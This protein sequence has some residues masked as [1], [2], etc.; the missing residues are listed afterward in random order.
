MRRKGE[1]GVGDDNDAFS[2][3]PAA[4]GFR[5]I[6]SLATQIWSLSTLKF[7]RLSFR[8]IER[9]Q[10]FHLSRARVTAHSLS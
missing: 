9:E 6:F 5:T 1:D 2:S 7:L 10:R 3:V 4:R 8:G